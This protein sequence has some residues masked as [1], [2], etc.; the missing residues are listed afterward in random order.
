MNLLTYAARRF[1]VPL[2]HTVNRVN[3]EQ[4]YS[5]KRISFTDRQLVA[6]YGDDE[7]FEFDVI[8]RG[9]A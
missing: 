8:I 2:S 4:V 5:L 6:T 1:G 7:D 9:E 3:S